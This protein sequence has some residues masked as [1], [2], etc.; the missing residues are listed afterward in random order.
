[1]RHF[2]QDNTLHDPTQTH[3]DT[4][5]MSQNRIKGPIEA[6]IIDPFST[7]GY[8]QLFFRVVFYLLLLGEKSEE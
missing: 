5:R 3:K 1:M 4:G 2:F 7:Q 8:C 6:D